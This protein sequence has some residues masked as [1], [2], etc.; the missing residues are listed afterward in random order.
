MTELNKTGLGIMIMLVLLAMTLAIDIVHIPEPEPAQPIIMDT[1]EVEPVQRTDLTQTESTEVTDDLWTKRLTVSS[2]DHIYKV[3]SFTDIPETEPENVKLYWYID[4]I[5]I[6]VTDDP[7]LDLRFLDTNRNG[8]IDRLAFTIPHLSTQ[9][10]EIR[11][12]LDAASNSGSVSIVLD[13]LTGGEYVPN[14]GSLT[15]GFS[16]L[17][18]PSVGNVMCNLTLDGAIL[19]QGMAASGDIEYELTRSLDSQL[20]TWQVRCRDN[21]STLTTSSQETFYTDLDSPTITLGTPSDKVFQTSFI[22]LNFTPHDTLDTLAYCNATIDQADYAI[23]QV[24]IDRLY[25]FNRSGLS[26]GLH[27]W[28]VTC[29]DRS[30]NMR[31]SSSRNIYVA[32]GDNGGFSVAPNKA[33][34]SLSESGYV[35][36]TADVPANL[37]LFI[38]KPNGQSLER[39]YTNPSYPL[40]NPIDYN[41]LYGEYDID[42][43]FRY[44]TQV[45]VLSTGFEVEYPYSNTSNTSGVNFSIVPNKGSYT[46]GEG[47]YLTIN[48]YTAANLTLF[49][50]SSNSD[51]FFQYFYRPSY[52]FIHTVNFSSRAGTYTIQGIFIQ[53]GEMHTITSSVTVDS[54][55]K[56]Q[57]KSNDT[58]IERKQTINLLGEAEGGIGTLT[59]DWDM[60]D[61]KSK[62]TKSISH[63]YQDI[64]TYTIELT[65]KDTKGNKETDTIQVD[66]RD[67]FTMKVSLLDAETNS[68][69]AYCW[70]KVLGEN[71]TTASNGEAEFKIYN[72]IYTLD[73]GC[74]GYRPQKSTV[75]LND[76]QAFTFAL[77]RDDNQTVQDASQQVQEALPVEAIPGLEELSEFDDIISRFENYDDELGDIVGYLDLITTLRQAEKLLAQ[78]QRDIDNLERRTGNKEE[79]REESL[80]KIRLIRSSTPKSLSLVSTEEFVAYPEQVSELFDGYMEASAIKLSKSSLSKY[81][82]LTEGMQSH[83][84]VTVKPMLVKFSNLDG[85]HSTKTFVVVKPSYEGGEDELAIVM[86]LIDGIGEVTFIKEPTIKDG[87]FVQYPLTDGLEVVFY[88]DDRLDLERLKDLE[89]M[90]LTPDPTKAKQKLTGFAISD[91]FS[92]SGSLKI[93]AEIIG[94]LVLLFIFLYYQFDLGTKFRQMNLTD[95]VSSLLMVFGSKQIKEVK[96]LLGKGRAL[97]DEKQYDLARNTHKE[98]MKIYNQMPSREREKVFGHIEGFFHEIILAEI[99]NHLQ[100]VN[101][102]IKAKDKKAAKLQYHEV[103]KLYEQLPK[104]LKKNV[105]KECHDVYGQLAAP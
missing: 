89:F 103:T 33:L 77:H 82:A 35:L 81:K 96:K 52:P 98:A 43:I 58:T 102:S 85:S 40:I 71:K 8:L 18:G 27:R 53:A 68:K 73:L 87:M 1:V 11:I 16:V 36:V 23:G 30:G 75:S 3:P 38:L 91:V 79:A 22:Q 21:T 80:E 5:A 101:S 10:F 76:N 61:G 42:A 6:D 93:T 25:Q 46:L 86:R 60:G 47:G 99:H 104:S 54:N 51:S 2:Q 56:V 65:V 74:E 83:L 62:T 41:N 24:L 26:E 63:T 66:V 9:E 88:K 105:S 49:I 69:M 50:S 70:V 12:I 32:S 67:R 92:D 37:T 57:I 14:A 100:G 72:G 19:K 44:G 48:S 13:S 90:V 17:Y 20:H 84:S 28:N 64:G 78:A 15:M 39:S 7:E 34:Y 97:V 55:L 29:T 4:G 59:Y 31:R 95:W 94:I 45:T